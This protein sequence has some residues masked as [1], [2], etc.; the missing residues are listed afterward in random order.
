MLGP[1]T[2]KPLLTGKVPIVVLGW[3]VDH[4]AVDVVRTSDEHGMAQAVDPPGQPRTSPDR[5]YRRGSQSHRGLPAGGVRE[6]DA[7][8]R[9]WVLHP[10]RHRR[11]VP[12]R[13]SA[14][15]ARCFCRR[16]T[17]R[18]RLSPTTTTRPWR[19]WVC[20]PSKVSTC[21]SQ[22]SVIGWDDSEAAALS[23]VGLTSVAQ[24]PFEMARLAVE[25]IVARIERRRVEGHEIVLEP[26]L[27]V[28][29]STVT[30]P[31]TMS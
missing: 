19:R 4:P 22:L 2:P 23:P 7:T 28:R 14:R 17:F 3:H 5:P 16:G 20:W 31:E 9:G 1:P 21:P 29:S 25:R 11:P 27:K 8:R 24:Q 12:A 18:R 26:E 13:W 6:G 10:H 15:C 30:V